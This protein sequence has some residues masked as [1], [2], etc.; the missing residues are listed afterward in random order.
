MRITTTRSAKILCLLPMVLGLLLPLQSALAQ[1]DFDAPAKARGLKSDMVRAFVP[2]GS[3]I[4]FAS[5][6]TAAASDTPGCTP[7]TT[8]SDFL[9][10]DKGK[11]SVKSSDKLESP[12]KNLTQATA[13][14]LHGPRGV[15]A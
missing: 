13:P 5:P 2:C 12:C 10:N 3:G 8:Y 11:C 14:T 15:A 6:N 7:P 1:C 9:F 4:T